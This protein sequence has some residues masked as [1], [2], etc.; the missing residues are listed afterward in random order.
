M[1]ATS[2]A[3]NQRRAD[4]LARFDEERVRVCPVA[5]RRDEQDE[6]AADAFRLA[7]YAYYEATGRWPDDSEA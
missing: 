6:R 4:A 1:A 2:T 5:D 7:D 3:R